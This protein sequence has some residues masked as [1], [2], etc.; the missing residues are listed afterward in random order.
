MFLDRRV[1]QGSSGRVYPLPFVD[2]IA[3]E[4]TDRAWKAVHLENEFVR[5][6]ILPELGGRIHVG[7]D[8]TNGY[9]FFYRQNVIKP[10]L[11]GLAGPWI[12]G[13]VEFNWPQ[14]HRPSTFMP[15]TAAIEHHADGSVTVWCGE[16]DPMN[17][18]S[19][20]HGVCLHP[21]RSVVELKVRLY[22]RTPFVQTFLWWANV[23]TRVHERYQSF[24]PP[25]VTHVAD[26][27]KRATSAFPLCA[28]SYYGVDYAALA[29]SVRDAG[30]TPAGRA[31]TRFVPPA[32][33]YAPNDLSWYANIP[34]P[35]SYMAMGSTQDFFGGYDHAAPGGGGGQGGAGLVHVAN[36][37]IAP[38]KKQWTWGNH[39]F[40]YAWDR[41]LSDDEGPYI[42]IMAG[43]YTDNQ[44][45]FSW[46]MPG[47]SRRWSQYWYPIRAIGPAHAANTRA[48][49]SL[50]PAADHTV[51]VGVAVTEVLPAA[52]VRL[53][54][55]GD[56]AAGQVLLEETVDLAPASPLVREVRTA[57]A[58]DLL[59]TV[60][61]AAG[62][63][64]LRHRHAP[65]SAAARDA[66][67]PD[68]AKEPPL[69]AAVASVEDLYLIG[70][71]LDQYRHATRTPDAY[72]QEAL[73]RD[74][75]DSRCNTAMGWWRLRRGEFAP[76]ADHFR[77][78]VTTLTR[79]NPNPR[80]G[81]PF[82]G[83]GLALRHLGRV[84]DAYAAFYKATWNGAWQA[85]AFYALAQI[86]C[87]RGAWDAA[88]AHL[89][90]VGNV[91]RGHAQARALHALVC[92]QLGRSAE[93]A[94]FEPPAA[95]PF[96]PFG[97]F[98]RDGSVPADPQ[99]RLDVALDLGAAGFFTQ[100]AALL[101]EPVTLDDAAICGEHARGALPMIGYTRAFFLDKAGDAAGAAA[102]RQAARAL[103]PDY[104]FPARLDD[105]AI[106][107]AAVAADP[108]DP[109]PPYYLATWLYDRNRRDEAIP[110]WE[111]AVHLDRAFA[112][113]WRNL[114]IAYFNV[115][116]DLPAAKGAYERAFAANRQ[117]ARLLY[118]RDQLW[119]RA[120]ESPERRLEQLETYPDLVA[121]RDDL[122]VELAALLNQLGRHDDALALL[123]RRRFQ[124]WEGGEGLALGQWARTH[125]ALGRR[126][127]WR[128]DAAAARRLFEAGLAGADSLG[129][130][131][132]L[133]ANAAEL[134]YW[135]GLACK[136][137]GDAEAAAHHLRR[138]AAATGDFRDMRVCAYSETA[139]FS[140]LALRELGRPDDARQLFSAMLAYAHR[141]ADQPATIDYFATSLPTMLLFEDDLARRQRAQAALLEAVARWG[142]GERKAART[143][144]GDLLRD[145][146]NHAAAADLLAAMDWD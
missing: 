2:R 40:G 78:A 96:D 42:E 4:K 52:R 95:D 34:V 25:D 68:P 139:C 75:A 69:P 73:R 122:S 28:G 120:G 129:E 79:Y 100:A 60:T 8:K 146:P 80:D 140:A 53:T 39:A 72:W 102:A 33:L 132:H 65:S 82:Y 103:P 86:D 126:A 90:H 59:L 71:H 109:R 58:E 98:V 91:S 138:A 27:A 144:L 55:G 111:K 131:R 51:R 54:R 13:G 63:E 3:E 20:V 97:A 85:A 11:V 9:D 24:F 16:H 44:P 88:L 124:P 93:T 125:V 5:V 92:R 142:L 64:I 46:L 61:D 17:R 89:D 115:S 1:Y 74:P 50:T 35:T 106:L 87:T 14:H 127:L 23:A 38:G 36:H 137:G 128:G 114:G 62:R 112:I 123:R 116:K 49:V 12:S 41:N 84:D 67:I 29:Q 77:Q 121:R 47:E 7:L 136:R 143:L 101:A 145:D 70:L 135:A 107:Q 113:P 10:A 19:G 22:N 94:P 18:M 66:K 31:G 118:E 57:T 133:L 117:D 104:C 83:L 130:A 99:L 108:A 43:V 6:M 21:G 26:H 32:G 105:L 134:D 37:H 15:T 81:E 119:K 76:A 30:P 48:A 56:T 141:L 110:W 45:D